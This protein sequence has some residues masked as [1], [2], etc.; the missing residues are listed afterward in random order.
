MAIKPDDPTSDA[1]LAV[2][3]ELSDAEAR[4]LAYA[5][6]ILAAT[7]ILIF[8][9]MAGTFYFFGKEQQLGPPA[10]PFEQT[11]TLP[12]SPRL[13]VNPQM[14]LKQYRD[15][16]WGVLTT[17]GWVDRSRGV[18]HIPI[19]RAMDLV[20]ARGLPTRPN[21]VAPAT[22]KA[23]GSGTIPG[24]VESNDDAASSDSNPKP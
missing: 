17:Y 21:S 23:S 1:S 5:G 22:E 4:P 15:S 10:T 16:Q 20:I 11:R 18:I 14:E 2:G 6:A 7:L 13:Q 3:H 8:V 12:P 24:P 19:D 9:A